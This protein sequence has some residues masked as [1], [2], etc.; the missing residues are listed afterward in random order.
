MPLYIVKH[1]RNWEIILQTMLWLLLCMSADMKI[2]IVI[3]S[4]SF[5]TNVTFMLIF[6]SMNL[7]MLLQIG[8][9]WKWLFTFHA[10]MRLLSNM[11]F[12]TSFQTRLIIKGFRTV[13]TGLWH[14]AISYF[15]MSMYV[16]HLKKYL[17]HTIQKY[18]I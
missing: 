4:E 14:N 11:D 12:Q 3:L 18:L 13:C 6:S 16:I 15:S 5:R 2:Q 10:L 9:F 1:E 17:L 7:K 8:S